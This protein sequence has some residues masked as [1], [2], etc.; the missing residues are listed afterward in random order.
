MYPSRGMADCTDCDGHGFK[1][2]HEGG[3]VFMGP[4]PT[5]AAPESVKDQGPGHL[6]LFLD[7]AWTPN[8]TSAPGSVA[9]KVRLIDETNGIVRIAAL[10]RQQ[11]RQICCSGKT[12]LQ[13]LSIVAVASEHARLREEVEELRRR[14]IELERRRGLLESIAWFLGRIFGGRTGS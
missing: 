4:C 14:V 7:L 9:W 10:T 11:M 6:G 13:W 1:F 3:D 2:T 8:E 5:C 12:G